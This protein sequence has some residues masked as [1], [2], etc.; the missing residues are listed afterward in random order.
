MRARGVAVWL[1]LIAAEFAHGIA[2]AVWLVP[3]VGD[4]P[5]RQIGVFTGTL[6]NLTIALLFI[7]WIHPARVSEAVDVGVVWC[8]LT[9]VFELLL[10]R[11]VFQ[12]S[13]SR[14]LSDYDLRHGG[15]LGLGLLAL[16]LAP[17]V[18]AKARRVF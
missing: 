12:A 8:L 17:L 11:L 1:V 7:R 9:L 5:S 6:I 3:V 4:F 2:R 18:A 14:L 13:W 16:A 15:Y 10:G